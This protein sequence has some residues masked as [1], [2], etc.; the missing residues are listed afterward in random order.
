MS[1]H[2]CFGQFDSDGEALY[3]QNDA[4]ALEGD[5]VRVTPG[6][7]IEDI[8][9]MG[10]KDDAADGCH[11]GLTDVHLLLDEQGAQHEETGETAEDKVRQMRLVDRH[12]FPPH[13][14]GE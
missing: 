10:A 12:L 4:G 2:V 14:D 3:N 13:L 1:L 6:N 8:G 5:L 9:S 7:G 11:G